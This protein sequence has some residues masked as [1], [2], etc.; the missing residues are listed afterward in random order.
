MRA[1]NKGEIE[2]LIYI[3]GT[4]RSG[5]TILE[6]LLS[7]SPYYCGA[8]ELTHFYNDAIN[9]NIHCSCQQHAK[10]CP[11]WKTLYS[12]FSDDAGAAYKMTK[13]D[14]H[15][16]FIS[17][18][19]P[20]NSR[21]TLRAAGKLNKQVLRSLI[22][23]KPTTNTVID[24][25]KY[26]G[27]ALMLYRY[28]DVD[29]KV[30]FLTRSPA[31][32]IHAFSKPNRY[33][34]LPKSPFKTCCYYILVTLSIFITKSLMKNS[35]FV[36]IDY[37]TLKTSPEVIIHNIERALDIDLSDQRHALTEL[38]GLQPGHIITGNRIRNKPTIH[39]DKRLS[40]YKIDTTAKCIAV[41][42]MN[43]TKRALK[44]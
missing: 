15:K 17:Q 39:F 14:S 13:F 20:L 32:L 38:N 29:T 35:D 16:G 22:K 9:H 21:A 6:I 27:R 10:D 11:Q 24:S 2:K 40:K 18:L 26:C 42:I 31:G 28:T 3:A 23:R 8:G 37:E 12:R 25:S 19:L 30:I 1:N 41:F 36:C 34:Q 33:E 43:L 5:S 4:A 44:L 7:N